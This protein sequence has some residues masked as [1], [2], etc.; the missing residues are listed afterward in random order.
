M[1]SLITAERVTEL[2]AQGASVG[3]IGGDAQKPGCVEGAI[4]NALMAPL[5]EQN[6]PSF[7]EPDPLLVAAYLLRS[8]SKNHCFVDGNKRAAWLAALEVLAVGAHLTIMADQ[9]EAADFVNAIASGVVPDVAAI[10]RWLAA[11]LIPL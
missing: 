2:H 3:P 10:T 8:L 4:G 9:V 7:D 1:P 11:R 5:Y 6:H